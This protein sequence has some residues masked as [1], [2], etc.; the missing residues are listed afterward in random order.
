MSESSRRLLFP[1]DEPV[2]GATL[3]GHINE[4]VQAIQA[5]D[6]RAVLVGH[7]YGGMVITG[8]ADKEESRVEA[9]VY[10]DA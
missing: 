8:A 3:E 5:R 2:K 6:A 7:S 9:I 4:V 10:A 1:G